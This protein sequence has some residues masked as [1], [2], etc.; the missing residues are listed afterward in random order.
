VSGVVPG[1]GYKLIM[2][3]V[4]AA[5]AKCWLTAGGAAR[6]SEVF[7]QRSVGPWAAERTSSF[8][9]PAR[10]AL[11]GFELGQVCRLG[12]RGSRTAVL[13]KLISSC[14]AGKVHLARRCW[15]R[16]NTSLKRSA[17]GRP[18][19]PGLLHTV[20]FHRPGPAVLPLSSA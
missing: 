8:A 12:P 19:G 15:L 5:Q 11:A 14:V 17:I 20:H 13:P 6:W 9:G 10:C 16:H 1:S 18:A 2:F 3:V 7:G 4:P